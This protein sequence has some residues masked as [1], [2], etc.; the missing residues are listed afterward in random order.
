M[1]L[2]GVR[3]P[4]QDGG[5]RTQSETALFFSPIMPFPWIRRHNLQLMLRAHIGV[6]QGAK[7]RIYS[8]LDLIKS[9]AS[10]MH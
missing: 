4:D 7:I 6:I 8:Y 10:F 5:F 1:Q 3:L 9:C 2:R